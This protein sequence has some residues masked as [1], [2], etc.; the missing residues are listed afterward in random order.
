MPVKAPVRWSKAYT[1]LLAC[2]AEGQRDSEGEE[3]HGA[4]GEVGT[5]RETHG[6]RGQQRWG[7]G[8]GV[9]GEAKSEEGR[10]GGKWPHAVQTGLTKNTVVYL[11]GHVQRVLVR[12]QPRG[13][14]Q[15]A[16]QNNTH[17]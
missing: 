14:L 1:E 9:R 17:T 13:V 12:H 3:T 2:R 10:E 8:H 16:L 6:A 5:A 7:M 15:S 4:K 11:F